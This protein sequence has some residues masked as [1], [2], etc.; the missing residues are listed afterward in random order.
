MSHE[1]SISD[2][3]DK[4]ESFSIG[5]PPPMEIVVI[6]EVRVSVPSKQRQRDYIRAGTLLRTSMLIMLIMLIHPHPHNRAHLTAMGATLARIAISRDCRDCVYFPGI[7]TNSLLPYPL[8]FAFLHC[9]SSYSEQSPV[10]PCPSLPM[11]KPIYESPL[12]ACLD[13]HPAFD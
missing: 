3:G 13:C 10:I 12:I 1:H 11:S 7:Y 8:C 6:A 5:H 2:I 9:Q 4:L